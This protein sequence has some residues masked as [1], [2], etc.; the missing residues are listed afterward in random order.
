MTPAAI[1]VDLIIE[2]LSD[3]KGLGDEW[4]QIDAATIIDIKTAWIGAIQSAYLAAPSPLQS[5]TLKW[6]GWNG[7]T[8]ITRTWRTAKSE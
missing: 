8:M 2:D 5:I 4:S 3:R 1:A 7:C 6:W